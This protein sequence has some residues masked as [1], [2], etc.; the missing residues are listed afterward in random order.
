MEAAEA[1][2]EAATEAMYDIDVWL[3]D[4]KLNPRS[5]VSSTRVDRRAQMILRNFFH[6]FFP[7]NVFVDFLT[8]GPGNF[9][10]FPGTRNSSFSNL[11]I[12]KFV[13]KN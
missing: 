4:S 2:A 3:A 8:F 13:V 12:I 5:M 9:F 6:S 7:P 10:I 11:N 1:A